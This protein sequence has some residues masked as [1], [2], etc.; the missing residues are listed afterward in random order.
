MSV[1]LYSMDCIKNVRFST[2]SQADNLMSDVSRSPNRG[3]DEKC[4]DECIVCSDQ[5]P[6]VIKLF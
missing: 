5:A 6:N 3:D 1:F 4:L 2:F